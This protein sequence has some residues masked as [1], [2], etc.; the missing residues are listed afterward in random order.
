MRER[1]ERG[2]LGSELDA[3]GGQRTLRVGDELVLGRSV[4]EATGRTTY[5]LHGT[6]E[7]AAALG[8]RRIGGVAD[9]AGDLAL[10]LQRDR[11]GRFVDLGIAATG[12]LYGSASLPSQLAAVEGMIP[13]GASAGRRWSLEQHLDLT[14]PGNAPAAAAFVHALSHPRELPAAARGL[15]ARLA[16]D[17]VTDFRAY[18]FV[19]D[20]DGI[21]AHLGAGGRLGGGE[22]RHAERAHL[23]TALQRGPEGIWRRRSDCLEA[24]RA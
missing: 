8:L 23:L 18:R 6:L 14:Q 21:G 2:G 19:A 11:G 16:H 17:A 22:D 20:D 7:L 4:D 9:A 5:A 10:M 13:T 15:A 12:E 24:V 1:I 3:V